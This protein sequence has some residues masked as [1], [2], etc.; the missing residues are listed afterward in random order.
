MGG[1]G[2]GAGAGAFGDG[3]RAKKKVAPEDAT[4][5]C[6]AVRLVTLQPVQQPVQQRQQPVRL[7]S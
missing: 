1:G 4:F 3:Q 2:S 6:F 5:F 7:L